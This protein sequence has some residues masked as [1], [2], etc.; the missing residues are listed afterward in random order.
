MVEATP[1]AQSIGTVDALQAT[2]RYI[3]VLVGF[4]TTV[5]A[6][7]KVHDIAGLIALIQSSGGQVLGAITGIITIATMAY[8]IF[9]TRKRGVQAATPMV[10]PEIK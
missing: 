2:M 6:L 3:V 10:L 1:K 4:I 9:K 8:G 7:V 5:L